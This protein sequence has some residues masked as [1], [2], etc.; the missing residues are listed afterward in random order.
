[1]CSL[2][3]ISGDLALLDS[4][5]EAREEVISPVSVVCLSVCVFVTSYSFGL[6]FLSG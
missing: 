6:F 1:M 2:Q 3:H 4:E 5:R